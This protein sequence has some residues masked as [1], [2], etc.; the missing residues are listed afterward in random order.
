MTYTN[1]NPKYKS[2]KCT[3]C[4]NVDVYNEF[5]VM[6][7][8]FKDRYKPHW[9][10]ISPGEVILCRHCGAEI[11]KN[12]S[13][14]YLKYMYTNPDSRFD[15]MLNETVKNIVKSIDDSVAAFNTLNAV[16]E[17]FAENMEKLNEIKEEE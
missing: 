5:V 16:A 13:N 10:E 17:E 2:Y 8:T 1:D 6:S 14:N 15:I 9:D 4:G 11:C 12:N 7:A 3:K